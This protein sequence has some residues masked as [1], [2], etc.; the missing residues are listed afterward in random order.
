MKVITTAILFFLLNVNLSAQNENG[1][2]LVEFDAFSPPIKDLI[3]SFENSKA[4]PFLAADVLGKEQYMGD[5]VDKKVILWFWSTADGLSNNQID[6]LNLL[7]S[8]YRN[9]LQI[10]SFAEEAKQELLDFRKSIPVDFPI[11][12]NGKILGEAAFGGDLGQGRLFLID[13]SGIIQKVIP[14]QA[15]E[16]NYEGAFKYAEDMLKSL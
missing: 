7:Q 15:F 10:I 11:I 1:H 8:R 12:A 13:Q 6:N 9:E 5:Y 14:R 2:F 16:E 4:A 3:A